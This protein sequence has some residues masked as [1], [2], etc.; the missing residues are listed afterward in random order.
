[1][2]RIGRGGRLDRRGQQTEREKYGDSGK[3][4]HKAGLM[5][6]R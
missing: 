1:M 2:Q 5:A 6:R 3:G 4:R